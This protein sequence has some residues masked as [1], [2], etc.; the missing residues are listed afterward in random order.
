MYYKNYL[1]Y[2]AAIVNA[3]V[4]YTDLNV[5]LYRFDNLI[6]PEAPPFKPV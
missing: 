4:C 1:R 6:H 3:T 2:A 5:M